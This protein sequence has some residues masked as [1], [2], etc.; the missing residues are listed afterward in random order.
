M[1]FNS[2][3]EKFWE[4]DIWAIFEIYSMVVPQLLLYDRP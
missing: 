2:N 4:I 3:D 1:I